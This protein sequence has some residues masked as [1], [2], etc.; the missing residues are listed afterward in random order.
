MSTNAS[1]PL[2][3]AVIEDNADLNAL[4]VQSLR[5]AG[6]G[7]HGVASVEAF[8]RS[9]LSRP[10]DLF[11]LD[12]NLPGEDGISFA[13]RLREARPQVGII[14]LTARD[15][16]DDRS[17]GYETGADIYLTKPSSIDELLGAVASLARRLGRPEQ[18]EPNAVGDDITLDQVRLEVTGPRGKVRLSP[19]EVEILALLAQRPDGQASFDEIRA[20]L[21]RDDDLSK[22]AIEIKIFRL[23]KKIGQVGTADRTITSVRS[24]GYR[25]LV[26]CALDP[27]A[28]RGGVPEATAR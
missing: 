3:I 22:S 28:A 20:A 16:V 9:I 2:A 7:S 25:L 4:L 17:R 1:G 27:I 11:I 5:A 21:R 23:R 10:P 24:L 15:A 26:P 14:M 8:E 13:R 18:A 6:Y 19:E 12:L